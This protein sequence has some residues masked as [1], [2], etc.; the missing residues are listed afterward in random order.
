MAESF[1]QIK[2]VAVSGSIHKVGFADAASELI[3]TL[4][5]HGI[6]VHVESKVYS[7]LKK[8]VPD[9][10]AECSELEEKS[11]LG[12]DLVLSLGGDGTFLKTSQFVGA[13]EIPILGI[14]LG[15]LGFLVDISGDEI[16]S[17]IETVLAEGF[18]TERRSLLQMQPV[19]ECTDP[20]K[21]TALNEI[22][23]LKTDSSSM[24]KVHAYV[25]GEFLCTYRADG[26]IVSTPTGSTA[27]AMSVGASILDPE[28]Q[29][30]ILAPVSPHT[31]NQRPIIIPDDK[32]IELEIEGRSAN[33][34]VSLDGRSYRCPIG[35]KISIR[36]APFSVLVAW[37]KGH[38]YFHT[39]RTKLMWGQVQ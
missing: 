32:Q 21:C 10:L 16:S 5:K 38:T 28:S 3:T 22:A 7:F 24:I 20:G 8:N 23:V 9:V 15:H 1:S 4:R 26:L 36:K 14:N 31:L 30:I 12:M 35:S 34:I 39:L 19:G 25:N 13:L 2:N 17:A 29:D 18:I 6:S 27:Y 33:C 37:R 11:L